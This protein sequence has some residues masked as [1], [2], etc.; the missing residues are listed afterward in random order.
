MLEPQG[1]IGL[2]FSDERCS[3]CMTCVLFASA[4]EFLA[5]IFL[6]YLGARTALA[7]AFSGNEHY[8]PEFFRSYFSTYTQRTANGARGKGPRQKEN[9]KYQDKFRHFRHFRQNVKNLKNKSSVLF[10]D[11]CAAP[12]FQPLL[13]GSDTQKNLTHNHHFR[14]IYVGCS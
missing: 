9:K 8:T 1:C 3:S 12:T 2:Q 7:I 4:Q 13:A 11:F 5:G 6:R 10:D 14:V